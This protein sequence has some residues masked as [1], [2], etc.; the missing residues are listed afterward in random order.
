MTLISSIPY[1]D[2]QANINYTATNTTS[3]WS[4]SNA[5]SFLDGERKRHKTEKSG[6]HVSF[7]VD[8]VESKEE[9]D[10]NDIVEELDTAGNYVQMKQIDR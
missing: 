8:E 3:D 2:K 5:G 9:G 10:D 1:E 7:A 4:P 6:Y